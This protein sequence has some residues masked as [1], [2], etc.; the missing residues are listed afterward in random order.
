MTH[1]YYWKD[2]SS[3]IPRDA[4]PA[5]KDV[6]GK[7]TYIG[8]TYIHN[9]GIFVMQI[10]PA[11]MVN[12]ID[13]A[14]YGV[15]KPTAV[16][17]ILCSKHLDQFS[18]ITTTSKTFHLDTTGKHPVVGGFD[19]VDNNKGMLHVGR[20]TYQGNIRVGSIAGYAL[21][22]A[23]FSF[24][25][26][27]T[28]QK[29]SMYEV[30]LY[31]IDESENE[32]VTLENFS[33]YY[34][35]DY[36][37]KI[38]EDA[39]PA[40]KDFNGNDTYVGQ[41]Y[42][43]EYGLFVAQIFPGQKVVD[44]PCY[45]IKKAKSDIKI[46]CTRHKDNFS[47]WPA[48]AKTFRT[49]T[50]NK[51]PVVGGRNHF[52]ND[53]ALL[54]IGR[55]MHEGILKIGSLANRKLVHMH[56]VHN[57]RQE[58]VDAYEV[59]IYDKIITGGTTE[60][61]F[62]KMRFLKARIV[63]A[64]T[65]WASLYTR[66]WPLHWANYPRKPRSRSPMLRY[67]KKG[68]SN[69]SELSNSIIFHFI[70]LCTR[71]KDNF[72]W[73]S[74]TSTSFHVDIINKHVVE[75]GYDHTTTGKITTEKFLKPPSQGV[76]TSMVKTPTSDKLIYPI[77]ASSLVK[78]LAESKKW[79]FSV[80]VY[81]GWKAI[82]CTEHKESFRWLD[83]NSTTFNEDTAYVQLVFGGYNYKHPKIL[84]IGRA[85]YNGTLRIGAVAPL[86]NEKVYF[87]F[88]DNGERQVE[89]VYEVLT[90]FKLLDGTIPED[91]LPGGETLQG[92]AT[93]IGQ[94]YIHKYGIFIG[95]IIPGERFMDVQ[96]YGVKQAESNI[97]ILCTRH[98]NK[99]SWLPTTDT[100]FHEDMAGKL[101]VA[102]G[103]NH[104]DKDPGVLD[105][106]RINLNGIWRIGAVASH[107]FDHVFFYYVHNNE[108][109]VVKNYE[110]LV[111]GDS[112]HYF[113][114][115]YT[116][117]ISQDALP[118]GKDGNGN[119]TY[120]GQ[121]YINDYGVFIG[122]IFP[123]RKQVDVQ[124]F[125]VKKVESNIKILCTRHKDK[126]SWL[127][128]TVST[129][130]TDT[131]DKEVVHGGYNHMKNDSGVLD[132][133]RVSYEGGLRVGAV[134]SHHVERV[135]LIR[136]IENDYYWRDYEGAVPDDVLVAGVGE[137][138]TRLYI[139]QVYLH[140]IGLCVGPITP[141]KKEV[142]FFCNGINKANVS[143]QI[144]CTQGK[145]KFTWLP[146]NSRTFQTDTAEEHVV[147]GGY[148][149][150]S[151]KN[152]YIGSTI[153]DGVT[154]IGPVDPTDEKNVRF[155][156]LHKG[157]AFTEVNEFEVLVYSDSCCVESSD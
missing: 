19:Q 16:V 88:V 48:T 112:P 85:T 64:K 128:T 18:W 115:E 145:K 71:H 60:G 94:V 11:A 63:T 139:G 142:E 99:F 25:G 104:T 46:L 32:N 22:N 117:E 2:Y 70:I 21:E 17:K 73:I 156:F 113:W 28:E 66:I 79:M 20:L 129:F 98:K 92:G 137:N 72:H 83:T 130:H 15:K 56:Y 49:D 58:K 138:N 51:H 13:L 5:G 147:I 108:Q 41:V 132:V 155:Y 157:Q 152:L 52:K 121:V 82:L 126:F 4:V 27:T 93:Y 26:G 9:L 107:H 8:Q 149:A 89:E 136:S 141:G 120:V 118:A 33:E 106:G 24:V 123:G 96:C 105:V 131:A 150:T 140:H 50:I 133:G 135:P 14:S 101:V 47:W 1:G 55:V 68:L 102:G 69:K 7:E 31:E 39:L 90:Y 40:G 29:A 77:M 148:N 10:F 110:V 76:K 127:P 62:Q 53:A 37:G 3:R 87:Y 111:Y 80:M 45:G 91:A 59:L 67:Q 34:W 6:N 116:G 134:A 97:K 36:Y 35:R 95:E 154:Q 57:D 146:T 75:G 65:H 38:P 44:V 100:T 42:I 84:N 124:C 61:K 103:F 151:G 109:K 81:R 23:M 30:L 54:N 143:I 119:D 78:F 43:H 122:E 144:L 86:K 74:T 114:R 12:Q 125:G 153:H